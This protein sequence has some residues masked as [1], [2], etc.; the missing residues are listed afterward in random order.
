MLM[1]GQHVHQICIRIKDKNSLA[2]SGN[3]IFIF[4]VLLL[5]YIAGSY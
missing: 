5:L 2:L 1:P 3:D 4:I